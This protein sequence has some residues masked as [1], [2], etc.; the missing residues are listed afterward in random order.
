M[1]IF[2]IFLII[3]I[4]Q[5]KKVHIQN[6]SNYLL[7]LA[8]IYGEKICLVLDRTLMQYNVDLESLL[9]ATIIYLLINFLSSNE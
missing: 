9:F 1:V 4:W 5:K 8:G 2:L 7:F 3:Y 6:I